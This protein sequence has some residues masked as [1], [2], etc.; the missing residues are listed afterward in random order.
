MVM[1]T[2]MMI[3]TIVI[4]TMVMVMIESTSNHMLGR[5]ILDKLPK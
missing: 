1:I 2:R 4:M 3:M 5:V